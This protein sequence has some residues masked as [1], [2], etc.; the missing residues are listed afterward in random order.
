MLLC[1]KCHD[2]L[3]SVERDADAIRVYC[4][5]YV[6]DGYARTLPLDTI[7]PPMKLCG[8]EFYLPSWYCFPPTA[9][10]IFR[11]EVDDGT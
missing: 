9:P 2:S 4:R 11:P 8:T 7:Q 3:W 6:M 5:G 10:K 1:P